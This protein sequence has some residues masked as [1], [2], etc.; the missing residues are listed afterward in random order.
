MSRAPKGEEQKAQ[1]EEIMVPVLATSSHTSDFGLEVYIN[2]TRASCLVDT[3]AAMSLISERLWDRT[4]KAGEQLSQ[5]GTNHKLVGVQG[6][7]LPLCGAT[8]VSLQIPGMGKTFPVEMLVAKSITTDVI[9]GRDFL[10]EHKCSVL[11]GEC[12]QLHF[13]TE[14]VTV[15]L[16]RNQGGNT[17]ASVGISIEES[18]EIPPQSEME[19]MVKTPSITPSTTSTWLVEPNIGDRNAVFVARAMVN[20]EAGEISVRIL[21]PRAETVTIQKGIPIAV[22]EPLLEK[23]DNL[24]SVSS[25][26]QTNNHDVSEQQQKQLWQIVLDTGD[27]LSVEEQQQLYAVLL[28]NADLFAEQPD[29]FG[30]TDKI[31]HGINTGD[32]A[33]VRQQVRRIPPVRREEARNLLSDML[34]KDIIQPSSSPWASPIVLVPKKDGTVRFCVD[35]RKVNSLTRKDAY[36]LPRVDDT[37]DTLSGSKWFSTLDLI[38]GYWQVKVEEKDREKTAFCTPDGLFEFKVMPFGLCNAPATFQRLMDMVLA[39]LQWTNCLVYLDDVIVVGRTF[40]EHLLNL[41]SVFGRLR[42]AGLKLQPKKCH[43]CSPKVEFLGHV[44][45]AE[46]VSTDPK[47]I[48][49]VANWPIPT[50][51]REVQQFLG[52]AN[53]YRRFV[54]DFAKI[55]KPLHRLTE[56]TMKFEWSADCQA[57]FEHL[58]QKLVSAPILAF[59]DLGKP[60]I[61]DTDASDVGIGAV[62]SQIDENG[63]ERVIAYA[64]KALTKPEHRYCVTRKELLAVVSFIQHF[65]PYLLGR[66]FTL[67]TDH[68]SLTWLSQFKEPEG[69]L[70]RWLER[71]QEYDFEICHRPGK[72]HQNA[73]V[74]SRIPCSQCGRILQ[75]D[76]TPDDKHE[77]SIGALQE[78]ETSVL[79][80]KSKTEIRLAQL[81]DDCVGFVLK[82]KEKNHK[83]GADDVKGKSMAVR[84]LIQLWDR[85]EVHDGVLWRL[86]DDNAGKKKWLQLIL[87]RSLCDE[88]LQEL[89]AGVVSGHLGEQKMLNQ[90]RERFY[91]PGMSEDVKNW[92][93]TCATCATRKSPAPKARAPLQTIQ[94]GYPMQVIAIDITGPFPESDA[95]NSYVLVVGD[96]FSKWVE[97]FAIPDQEATTVAAKLVDE[98]YCRFSPPEQLHS[99]QG[100]QFESELVKEICKI[101]RIAKSRTTPYHPQGDGL[102]ERFNRTLKQML[103]T[104]L[105]DYLFDWE[106]RLRKVCMAYNTSVHCSTGYTPFYLMY[107]REARLPIDIA[108]GTKTPESEPVGEYAARLKKS[109]TEAYS[110]VQHQLETTHQRQKEIYDKKVHGKPYKKGDLVWLYNPAIPQGQARKLHHPWTGP[111]RVLE[112]IGEADYRIKEVYGKRAP[113]VV[114][115]DR[116]KPCHPGTRFSP[117]ASSRNNGTSNEETSTHIHPTNVFEMEIVEADNEDH[118]FVPFD[119]DVAPLNGNAVPLRR[120]TRNRQQPERLLPVVIR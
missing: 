62:L 106:E 97:A 99:D 36:P 96:Y 3:G 73:D 34:K 112:R 29:D 21:N 120:S 7:P 31:K 117:Q 20:P 66:R 110:D 77:K 94:A 63:A 17:I 1:L 41:Q 25:V 5:T 91:W 2:H 80:E 12:N 118:N 84:R 18:I 45:S 26:E 30:R 115:F 16:G 32:A 11:L 69:Q 61:L 105:R 48:E 10:Q 90:L 40:R 59:P 71:L 55:A 98:V 75:D 87:P 42:A 104:T 43:L 33:P 86:Y 6:L 60:F 52:L 38:S 83:P 95:G 116:L 53:Y 15:D 23:D 82:A 22:M 51:K 67:R 74:L 78:M 56:K 81:Q 108:Y 89:H 102:V 8:Q 39:G 37:L 14:R 44:V 27:K 107:G 46:G 113:S 92:C 101:L 4:K 13:T 70:A 64:S 50:S 57:S 9:L 93:Q 47:K 58:R 68:G 103:A 111:F 76:I 19:I 72:K 85:L 114:H 109:L 49:K 24:V 54:E 100:R 88:V 79:R 35:Y 119:E 28:E 65:R